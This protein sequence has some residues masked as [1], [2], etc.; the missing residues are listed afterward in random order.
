VPTLPPLLRRSRAR[1]INLVTIRSPNYV[2]VQEQIGDAVLRHLPR[3]AVSRSFDDLRPG[4]VNLSLF[5]HR[6][7]DVLLSHGLADKRY[8]FVLEDESRERRINRF[9][10]VLV[11][12][13]WMRDQ[14]LRAKGVELRPDQ[15]HI[16]GWPRLD[17]LLE[18][19]R[20]VDARATPRPHRRPRVL[21][22]PSHDRRKR[23]PE[24]ESTS[25]YPAF[26]EHLPELREHADVR[27]SVHPINREDKR[28]TDE[29]LLWADVVVSDF[30]TMVYEAW[31]LGKPVLFPTWI[32]RDRVVRYLRLSAEAH[33]F[34]E[35]IGLHPDSIDELIDL[36]RDGDPSPGPDVRA[37]MSRYLAPDTLGR[38]GRVAAAVLDDIRRG[39]RGLLSDRRTRGA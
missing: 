26:E 4:A 18:R 3:R 13:E 5:I 16:V 30:G 28:P 22:A 27:V 17:S 35:R 9:E 15:I 25:S 19:Q 1:P 10:H 36:V 29:A 7:A 20:R 23:G 2:P 11:P 31:A 38:S 32:L 12:G 34:R 39:R 24:Q 37:F 14:L 6:P 8:F 21:W 33:I